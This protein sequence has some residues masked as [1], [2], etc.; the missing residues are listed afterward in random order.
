LEEL[1]GETPT[2]ALGAKGGSLLERIRRLAQLEPNPRLGAGGV[3]G[4]GV[5]APLV[6]TAVVLTVSVAQDASPSLAENKS[7]GSNA[8]DSESKTAAQGAESETKKSDDD[9][10]AHFTIIAAK[11]VLLLDGTQI[12]TWQDI[13]DK[14]AALP[15]P[16]RAYPHLYVTRGTMEAGLD[17]AAQ[18]EVFEL[19]RKYNLTGHSVGTLL[20]RND[21]HYDRIQTPADLVPDPALRR[22]GTVVDTDGRPIAGAE[23]ILITPVD[24]SLPYKAYDIVMFRPS[25][26]NEVLTRTDD[27]DNLPSTRR[28]IRLS[29]SRAHPD[30]GIARAT[31]TGSPSSPS[32]RCCRGASSPNSQEPEERMPRCERV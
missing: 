32:S 5:V 12:V 25:Q 8:D 19:H 15:D 4:I 2:L 23:V 26:S 28:P 11:H 20:P 30:S 22:E 10:R 6:L 29:E 7:A 16:S 14:I 27:A 3:I 13:D 17:D 18:H 1:R 21:F 24:E 9:T 31:A